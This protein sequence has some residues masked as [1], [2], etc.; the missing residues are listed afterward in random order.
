MDSLTRVQQRW[1]DL[2]KKAVEPLY[3]ASTMLPSKYDFDW[4]RSI[5]HQSGHPGVR[6]TLYFVRQVDP[7]VSKASVRAVVRN[8]EKCQLIDPPP[9][10]W[11]R[12]KLDISNTRSQVGM[13]VTLVGRHY[14]LLID[15]GP[16]RFSI[17]CHLR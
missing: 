13:D 9:T 6:Q 8:C 14:L 11:L 7:T 15:C 2:I 10:R 16:T 5:N 1:F 4:T 12:G 3:C 17:W